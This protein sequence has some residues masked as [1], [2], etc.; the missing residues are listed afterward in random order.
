ML[1]YSTLSNDS[2]QFQLYDIIK[3]KFLNYRPWE[4]PVVKRDDLESG[5][6]EI[7]STVLKNTSYLFIFDVFDD[8]L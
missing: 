8:D 2:C 4:N 3:C 1:L 7:I 5:H 6:N